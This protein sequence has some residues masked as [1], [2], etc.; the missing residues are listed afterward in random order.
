M[1]KTN[2]RWEY[3]IGIVAVAL[4]LL[5]A[6]QINLVIAQH[7]NNDQSASNENDNTYIA[8]IDYKL[9][10]V[11]KELPGFGGLFF[12][13]EF[14]NIYLT[15]TAAEEY[16]RSPAEW[17]ERAKKV[18]TKVFGMDLAIPGFSSDQ[19]LNG[20]SFTSARIKVSEGKYEVGELI[21]WRPG[22]DNALG[23]K[24]VV[25]TDFDKRR[26]RLIIGIDKKSIRDEVILELLFQGVPLD[27]VIIEVTEE[28]MSG[29]Y[30]RHNV[31]PRDQMTHDSSVSVKSKSVQI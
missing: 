30:V 9:V 22:I 8:A 2:S 20:E 3:P 27:A 7:N 17:D 13:D 14:L 31:K 6:F 29:E 1:K 26:N 12:D 21:H 24:G 16:D 15:Q 5:L 19:Y 10:Q 28:I 11:A 18:L 25:L 23:I 4:F